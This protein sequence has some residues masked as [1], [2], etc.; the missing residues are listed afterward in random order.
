MLAMFPMIGNKKHQNLFIPLSKQRMANRQDVAICC[1]PFASSSPA[2]PFWGSVPVK[3]AL[4]RGPLSWFGK[5]IP[6]IM[7]NLGGNVC[8]MTI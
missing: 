6:K 1:S 5:K 2:K 4:R 7:E 3:R 8:L